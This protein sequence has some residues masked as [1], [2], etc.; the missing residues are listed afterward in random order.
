MSIKAAVVGFLVSHI[1]GMSTNTTS[2]TISGAS[3]FN[4][5][6]SLMMSFLKDIINSFMNLLNAI[7][8]GIGGAIGN[9]F[10]NWGYNV[11]STFGVWAP[12]GMVV[13]LGVSGF[14]LYV[15]MDLYR[16]EKDIDED[17]ADV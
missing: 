15:F 14:V 16:G 3:I 11:S 13:I 17:E 4:S 2:N 9:V 6:W 7:F 12:V 8:G 10:S 1:H 5:I